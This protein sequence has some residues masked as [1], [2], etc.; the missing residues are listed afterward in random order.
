MR[1]GMWIWVLL[2]VILV[3]IAVG[4]GAYNAGLHQGIEDSGRAVEV[5]RVV[6]GRGFFP[7]GLILFPLFLF[8]IFALFRAAFWR[9]RWGGPR[10]WGPGSGGKDGPAMFEEWHRR[11]HEQ[12]TGDHPGAGGEPAAV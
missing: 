6:D 7:F 3:G 8:G 1:R 2:L 5:V 10:H 12:A 4:V 9:G 11:Q